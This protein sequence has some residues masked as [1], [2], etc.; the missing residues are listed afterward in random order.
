LL[1]D[2]QHRDSVGCGGLAH[3]V[4][5]TFDNQRGEAERYLI[6]KDGLPVTGHRPR[7]HKYLLRTAGEQPRPTRQQGLEFGKVCDRFI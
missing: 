1:F 7:E 3:R 6:G 5:Q 2:E 4:K